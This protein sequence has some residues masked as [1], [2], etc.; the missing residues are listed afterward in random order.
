MQ[1]RRIDLLVLATVGLGVNFAIAAGFLLSQEYV[2][3]T[4]AQRSQTE[5]RRSPLATTSTQPEMV[6]DVEAH[7]GRESPDVT[8][9]AYK[10]P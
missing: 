5:E 10:L 6:E 8:Q 3:P 4:P 1:K 2:V 7:G 9:H